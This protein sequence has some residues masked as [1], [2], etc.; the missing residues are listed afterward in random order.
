MANWWCEECG[1][2]V[3]LD[4]DVEHYEKCPTLDV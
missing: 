1:K 4:F 3:D 2:L